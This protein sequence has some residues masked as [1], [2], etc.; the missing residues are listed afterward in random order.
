MN[1]LLKK[2][3]LIGVIV[4]VSASFFSFKSNYFEISKNLDIFASLYKEL[5]T[6]YVDDVEPADLIRKGIDAMLKSL[7]PYTNYISEAEI[8]GYKM[9][10]TGKYGGIGAAIRTVGDYVIITE[11]YKGF[12]ADKA[13][14]KAGDKIKEIEGK[15][16]KGKNSDQISRILRGQPGTEVNFKVERPGEPKDIPIKLVREQVKIKSVPYSGIID[17]G[18]G[19]IKLNS[20]TRACSND[21]AQALNKLKKENELQGLVFDLRG[22]RG[23]LLEEAR[24]VSNI[25]IE[26]DKEI[27][28]T[29]GKIEEWAKTLN[30]KKEAIDAE[31]PLV[32]L[33][34]KASASASEIVSGVVQDYD[35]GVIVGQRTFG[36]GLVQTTKNLGYNS[37]LKLTTAKYYIPSGRCIQAINY[38]EKGEDG[39]VVKIPDSLR[40]EF[41]TTNG[42]KVYDGGGVEPDVKIEQR[43]YANIT[44]SLNRN[45]HIFN[46]ATEYVLQKD[47]IVEPE[48]F[49]LTDADFNNF[50]QYLE[51]KEYDYKTNSEK[52]LEELKEATEKEN[53]LEAVEADLTQLKDK[54][55][56]DKDNDINKHK[57]EILE[58]IE[59]EII[60]RYYYSEGK[61]RSSLTRDE[62]V[63]KAIELLN[64]NKQYEDILVSME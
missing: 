19:Y 40:T 11:P 41:K 60:S 14:L 31:I 33:T 23:G 59:L 10:T 9:Q 13:G 27:V 54:I 5:N 35:R 32:V 52:L 1:N 44:R 39:E 53:Y 46:F 58:L 63:L 17:D 20:F 15:T 47:S 29:K 7:D 34:N 26:K 18:I 43:K 16:C 6:Y 36:K 28:S 62:E 55:T 30:A 3:G 24:N 22:N 48:D 57:E 56:D 38:S 25:F 50:V 12:P 51:D 4:I 61:I 49:K 2:I 64:D 21:V 37:K 8:E 45:H 42:R